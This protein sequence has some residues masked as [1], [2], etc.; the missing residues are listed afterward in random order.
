MSVRPGQAKGAYTGLNA[1]DLPIPVELFAAIT[2][3]A[4]GYAAPVPT[5]TIYFARVG[6]IVTCLIPDISG[7]SNDTTLTLTGPVPAWALPL[8]D[9]YAANPFRG[10]DNGFSVS[11][12]GKMSATDGSMEF[13]TSF[14][15]ASWTATGVKGIRGTAGSLRGPMQS[16][17]YISA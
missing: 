11:V 1:A 6:R 14:A 2:M 4:T 8:A 17:T 15:G 13:Y 7:D 10:I 3:T 12:Y 9:V 5:P 16:F